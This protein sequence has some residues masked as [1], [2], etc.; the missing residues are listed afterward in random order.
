[1]KPARLPGVFVC[2]SHLRWNFVYHRP[3]HLLSRAAR[4]S[5]VFFIEES[6]FDG[7]APSRLDV[8]SPVDGVCVV[9][10][11]LADA[12]DCKPLL[13]E[14]FAGLTGER[15]IAWYYTPLA[16]ELGRDLEADLVVYDC[17]DEL[18]AF[19][20]APPALK[21]AE[22]ELLE[23]ADVVFTGGRSLFEAKRGRHPNV[24]A[25]PSSVDAA[26]FNQA[27][28]PGLE[29][30]SDMAGIPGPRLGFFG[31]IDE[32]LD[33]DL[34]ACM[35]DLRPDWSFV[36]L[37][38]VVKIDPASLPRRANIHWIGGRDY[39]DLPRY[40]AHWDVGIMPFALNEATRF[41]SPT[42]TPEFLAAGL[43]VVSSAIADVVCPYG[44][45][46]L[47]DI[48][49]SAEEFLRRCDGLL[50]RRFCKAWLADVDDYLS[51]LSWDRTWNAMQAAMRAAMPRRQAAA[52]AAAPDRHADP[53]EARNVGL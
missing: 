47:V 40:L 23:R 53:V 26:H 48:A 39:K 6:V 34:L 2:F 14:L 17:M 22:A 18:S 42:K 32:R 4:T 13:D 30:P 24:H 52:M 15:L 45:L 36:M 20:F 37:G 10:P 27:R 12:K 9:K 33:I 51:G 49:G 7:D 43:P 19:A 31:V 41:I 16:L 25:F 46:G 8:S 5:R 28:Q 35:A 29:A 44:E 38:P 3:Q 1:M 50:A 21:A 11:V